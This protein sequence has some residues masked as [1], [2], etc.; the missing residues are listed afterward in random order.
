MLLDRG[1]ANVCHK[2]LYSIECHQPSY[3]L[4]F[5]CLLLTFSFPWFTVLC[6]LSFNNTLCPP[7]FAGCQSDADEDSEMPTQVHWARFMALLS[8]SLHPRLQM[9]WA[10]QTSVAL[11]PLSARWLACR[12]FCR[13]PSHHTPDWPFA[14]AWFHFTDCCCSSSLFVNDGF[15]FL[16]PLLNPWVRG[17]FSFALTVSCVIISF[18]GI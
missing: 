18:V 3:P 4:L 5:L 15:M 6:F 12:P 11:C 2:M 16:F 7:L 17:F 13:S 14:L 10:A 8:A 9:H 1:L